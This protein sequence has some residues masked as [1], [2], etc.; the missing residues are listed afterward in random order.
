MR[1]SV[2]LAL[3]TF[4]VALAPIA[5]ASPTEDD[6]ASSPTE[7]GDAEDELKSLSITDA[8]NGKTVTVTKGQSIL[9]KLQS[10]PTTGYKW[11]VASTDRT[12]GY[13]SSERYV[14]NGEN[15][16]VGSGGLQR[17]TWKTTSPLELAG[18][19]VVR[20]EYKRPWETNVAPAKVFTFTVKVVDGSCP[21]LSPPAPGVCPNGRLT[22]KHGTNNCITGYECIADCRTNACGT[23]QKCS[24]CWGQMACIPN[25]ALC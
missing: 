9:V 6:N 23:G 22:P 25:G 10:N 13:P 14:G 21:Q 15:G 5:C 16:P 18:S 11:S 7:E 1:L 19:H 8:D 24:A 3:A 20:L 4:A 12:F 17:F 2:L